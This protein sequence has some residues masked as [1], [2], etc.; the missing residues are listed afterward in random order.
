MRIPFLKH[1]RLHFPSPRAR[2]PLGENFIPH[3][4]LYPPWA[5]VAP[6]S[7]RGRGWGLGSLRG[8]SPYT[9]RMFILSRSVLCVAFQGTMINLYILA[10]FSFSRTPCVTRCSTAPSMTHTRKRCNMSTRAPD[11]QSRWSGKAPLHLCADHGPL[12]GDP[13]DRSCLSSRC[14]MKGLAT[15]SEGSH[16][17]CTC[18]SHGENGGTQF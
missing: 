18:F 14:R 16:A 12:G 17:P 13:S 8:L 6:R 15:G 9:R 2:G 5:S 4:W 3:F 10:T 11:L 7:P 1:K